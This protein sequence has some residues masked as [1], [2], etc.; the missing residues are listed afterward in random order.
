M[1]CLSFYLNEILVFSDATPI[2]RGG[3]KILH[4]LHYNLMQF[5][6]MNKTFFFCGN[7]MIENTLFTCHAY[8][9]YLFSFQ[10]LFYKWGKENDVHFLENKCESKNPK[11]K[12]KSILHYQKYKTFTSWQ[13]W[14]FNLLLQPLQIFKILSIFSDEIKG[15]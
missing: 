13:F 1:A 12:R 5:L 7:L 3:P 4:I 8:F 2:T 11:T 14:M 10:V 9:M 15:T 6:R